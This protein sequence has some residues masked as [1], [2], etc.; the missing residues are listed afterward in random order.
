MVSPRIKNA[1]V[2]AAAGGLLFGR[3][4]AL[5]GASLG[6]IGNI[7]FFKGGKRCRGGM[8]QYNR[9]LS[10]LR[11]TRCGSKCMQRTYTNDLYRS[12]SPSQRRMLLNSRKYSADMLGGSR[13]W[14]QAAVKKS[15]HKGLF[16]KKASKYN[17]SAESFANYVLSH[18]SDFDLRTRR[19]AQF[20]VN[21]R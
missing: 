4:G 9:G 6:G 20:L 10:G 21:I 12:R 18:K 13:N 1:V 5:V 11:G 19:E 14:I 8:H 2:G 17:M 3:T 7:G 16:T 15:K